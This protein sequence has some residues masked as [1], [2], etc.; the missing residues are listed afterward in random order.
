[1]LRKEVTF[2][3]LE[4]V[5][6]TG[7]VWVSGRFLCVAPEFARALEEGVVVEMEGEWLREG[8]GAVTPV[9]RW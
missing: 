1:V 7:P 8:E 3:L 9:L 4:L 2:S 5:R 6:I